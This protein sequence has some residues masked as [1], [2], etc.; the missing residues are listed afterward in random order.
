[1][2]GPKPRPAAAA[3]PAPA[4]PAPAAAPLPAP[5]TGLWSV[6]SVLPKN[7]TTAAGRR[8]SFILTRFRRYR[9]PA[10]SPHA[11]A[12]TDLRPPDSSSCIA[13]R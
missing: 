10:S 6:P 2:P 7:L 11:P 3:A 8:Q 5:S 9:M 13:A 4:A 12:S 1:M